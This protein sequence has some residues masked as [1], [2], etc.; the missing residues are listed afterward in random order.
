MNEFLKMC[1]SIENCPRFETRIEFL[2]KPVN[3]RQPLSTKKFGAT[4]S[5]DKLKYW[6]VTPYVLRPE[7]EILRFGACKMKYSNVQ[8]LNK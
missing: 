3:Q 4:N 8:S 5:L 1:L 6:Y 7:Y 2:V